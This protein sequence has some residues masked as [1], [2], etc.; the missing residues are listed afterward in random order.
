M[1]EQNKI[2]S[3]MVMAKMVHPKIKSKIKLTVSRRF[4]DRTRSRSNRN[5]KCPLRVSASA[6][7]AGQ[8]AAGH[9]LTTLT[10]AS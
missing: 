10:A 4:N 7:G 1:N 9:D 5:R 6:P 2:K 3:Q 8:L